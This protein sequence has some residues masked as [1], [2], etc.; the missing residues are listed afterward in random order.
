MEDICRRAN[1]PL[2]GNLCGGLKAALG[3]RHMPF[4][5][6]INRRPVSGNATRLKAKSKSGAG[7]KKPESRVIKSIF[8][9]TFN[10]VEVHDPY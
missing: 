2:T 6:V 4:G 3:L 8:I 5:H 9:K 7:R 10:K 1:R